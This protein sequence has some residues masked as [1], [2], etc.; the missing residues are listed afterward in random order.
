MRFSATDAGLT[1][2]EDAGSAAVSRRYRGPFPFTGTLHKVVIDV[3]GDAPF[4]PD[5]VV[6]GALNRD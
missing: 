6:R 3:T 4:D 2:G 5:Q 1:C